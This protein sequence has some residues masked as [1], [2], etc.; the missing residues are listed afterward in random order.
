MW[1]DVMALRF[2]LSE[3]SNRGHKCPHVLTDASR[4]LTWLSLA[5][6]YL[7]LQNETELSTACYLLRCQSARPWAK[8][9]DRDHIK[10]RRAGHKDENASYTDPD[11]DEP[12][13]VAI[14]RRRQAVDRVDHADRSG[15]QTSG[16]EFA[17]VSMCA[18]G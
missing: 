12:D 13:Q 1:L 3:H 8:N 14:E 5:Q 11:H 16:E 10:E 4:F 7:F 2:N 18:K 17:S 15:T 6:G 9:R